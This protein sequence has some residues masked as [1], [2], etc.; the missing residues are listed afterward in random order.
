MLRVGIIGL[1]NVGK[2][3]LFNALTL[4][5]AAESANYPFCTIEPNVGIVNVADKRLSILKDI[6]KTNVVIPATIEFVDIA[7]LVKGAS[8]G[9]GLGNQFL[10]HIREVN[11][12]IH[13]VR[14]FNNENIIHVSEKIDPIDDIEIINTELALADL[15]TI[16]K[17]KDKLKKQNKTKDKKAV[18]EEEDLLERLLTLLNE[19]KIVFNNLFNDEEN[20]FIDSL[21]LLCT[22]PIIYIANISEADL[23]KSNDYLNKIK[24]YAKSFNSQVIP[25]CA[26]IESELS[27]LTIEEAKEFLK[28]INLENFGTER[29]AKSAY[30]LLNLRTFFTAGEKEV[31]AW[32]INAGTK[33]LQ[34]AGKI[35]SDIER[36]FIRAEVTSYNDFVNSGSYII[37]KEKGLTRLEGKEYIVQDGDIIYFRF[38]V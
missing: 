38:S 30:E 10:G 35:H 19:G 25:I 11:A 37:A 26:Q 18:I 31:K 7:G 9:E 29:I 27:D 34:A 4:S 20:I 12:I 6:V 2:S 17:R 36:G 8:K 1:P 23:I 21:N 22:K 15:V 13:V 32:T 16:E 28:S 3:T 5:K 14:C 24:E 33:A